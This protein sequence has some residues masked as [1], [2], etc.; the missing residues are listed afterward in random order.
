V[1]FTRFSGPVL[2]YL[3]HAPIAD[4]KKTPRL[5]ALGHPRLFSLLSAGSPVRKS[6]SPLHFVIVRRSLSSD[7]TLPEQQPFNEDEVLV[8]GSIAPS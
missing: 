1:S 5:R 3:Q 4:V 7:P 2:D 8:P 6:L